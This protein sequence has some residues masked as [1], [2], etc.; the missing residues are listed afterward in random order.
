MFLTERSELINARFTAESGCR[1]SAIGSCS[2][3]I[4]AHSAAT[5]TVT[6]LQP[7]SGMNF[8]FDSTNHGGN[9]LQESHAMERSLRLPAGHYRFGVQH[10]V[11]IGSI[12]SSLDD[13]HFAVEASA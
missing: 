2:V 4:V 8:T 13:W 11:S 5:G 10:A 3:R 7:A 9:D 6:E 1:G 12:S